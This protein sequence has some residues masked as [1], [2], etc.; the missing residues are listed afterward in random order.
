MDRWRQLR[1]ILK[2]ILPSGNVYFQPP[3]SVKIEY[4]CII[5][6]RESNQV[7]MADDRRYK[8]MFR[9]SILY[10]RR[11][12]DTEVPEAILSLPLCSYD[13]FYATDNLNHDAFSIFY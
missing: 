4:P 13:R 10:I 1:D 8:S 2:S 5:F 6:E 9:Y 12:N 7:S 11:T 3:P